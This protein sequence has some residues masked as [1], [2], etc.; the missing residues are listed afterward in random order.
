MSFVEVEVKL[1]TMTMMRTNSRSVAAAVRRTLGIAG[2][3]LLALTTLAAG[4]AAAQDAQDAQNPESAVLDV[5]TVTGTR[6]VRDGYEAP[7]PI[8]VLGNEQLSKMATTNLADSVNRLPSLSGGRSS[9]NYSGNVSSGT[10]GIN[11][12]NLRGLGASRTLVLLDGKRM[13]PATLG[14]GDSATGAPDVNSIPSALIQRVEIVTGG[15]SAVYGSDALAGVVNFILDKEFTGVKGTAQ[16]G[17]TTYGDNQSQLY[18]LAMGTPFADSR[19]HVL[20]S[21]EWTGSDE[22]RGNDRP[23]NDAGYQLITNPAYRKDPVTGLGNG[24]PELIHVFN[25]GLGQATPGGLIQGCYL[26]GASASV[27]CGLRGTDFVEGGQPLPFNFGSIISNP[28]MSGGDWERSRNDDL[29]SLTMQMERSTAFGRASFDVTD[30]A[31]VYAELGWSKTR[32]INHHAL[33]TFDFN[34]QISR[35]NPYRPAEMRQYMVTNG[36]DR[37]AFGT[38][39]GDL[40]PVQGDN[41]RT[42]KRYALGA[43][44]TLDIAGDEWSWDAYAQRSTTEA[45]QTAPG[46]RINPNY[47]KAINSA[48]DASGRIVCSINAVTVVDPS[49]LP[50]NPF[51]VGVN[52]QAVIDYITEM[53][54]ANQ[55]LTQDVVAASASGT[56]FESW[57]G[58]VSLA[59]GIEHRREEVEGVASAIDEA[60]QFFAGNW[61]ASKGDYNVTEG[62][63]ETVVP[64]AKD[65]P[66]AQTVDLNAAAR[67]TDYSTS[68]DVV[69]WKLGTTWQPIDD[70]RF[71]VTRSRDIRAPSLGDLFNAGQSGGS[72]FTDPRVDQVTGKKPQYLVTSVTTGNPLLVPEEADTTGVGIVLS[73]RFIPGFT[74][75]IDYYHIE[76]DG[77]IASLGAQTVADRCEAGFA[78]LCQYV[79]RDPAQNDK[80]T[81]VINKPQNIL[82]QVASG[83]DVEMSYRLPI[84]PGDLELRALG[85]YFDKLETQDSTG[86]TVDGSGMNAA[87]AGVGFGNALLSPKYRYLVS[88]GYNLDP[89]TATLTMRGVSSG[90]YNNNFIV[91]DTGCPTSTL[92]NPTVDSNHIDGVK[93]FDLSLNG[94]LLDTGAELFFVVENLLN[95][96]PALVAGTRGGG[97]YNGQDNADFYDRLGRYFRAGVRFQF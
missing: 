39:N 76:I 74:M 92:D 69:T 7:T 44:G 54:W 13:V 43:E 17:E 75:S 78:E 93:Y 40:P 79:I 97:Y 42:F 38:V 37:L 51:G 41:T 12:L 61:H 68:G 28:Y 29:Q 67:W 31:T 62:F 11:T 25:A 18:S 20:V 63:V 64:L 10:A 22:I 46:N 8:S 81:T 84:G 48:R 9:H 72:N 21:A 53:G 15:A 80:I 19:G 6:I 88:V 2:S 52:S 4:T 82:G 45:L 3:T 73:P 47:N 55:E 60:S 91:C 83:Y 87:G 66:F 77:A 16:Y 58:P 26:P 36:F 57:A 34:L 32:A 56:P 70:I 86:R 23:W 14:T 94:K 49:C 27:N 5:V 85:T 96:E 59:F 71:R 35:D 50:Y 33:R 90:K 95:E 24:V 30:N 89:V 65:L 1:M